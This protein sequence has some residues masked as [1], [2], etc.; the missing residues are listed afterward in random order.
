MKIKLVLFLSVFLL[1]A[2]SNEDPIE[3]PTDASSQ[4][5]R[6]KS[7]IEAYENYRR[8][9]L[10]KYENEE[11]DML[12]EAYAENVEYWERNIEGLKIENKW[13]EDTLIYND[14]FS[15]VKG[16][17]VYIEKHDSILTDGVLV[18]SFNN[19]MLQELNKYQNEISNGAILIAAVPFQE[20][21]DKMPMI[22]VFYSQST[23]EDIDFEK[24]L[25]K[26]HN[27]DILYQNA[28]YVNT[29]D[30]LSDYLEPRGN[31]DKTNELFRNISG[32]TY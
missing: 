13:L 11:L 23:L 14:E 15:V 6:N 30:V 9:E 21:E 17:G 3:T 29:F 26:D 24:A 28:D 25:D 31:F 5:E 1:V 4:I 20:G 22:T 18:S 8:Q 32:K 12:K 27:N 10:E 2:C 19:N 16:T 7:S